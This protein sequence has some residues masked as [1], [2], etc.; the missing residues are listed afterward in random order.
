MTLKPA[1]TT[2]KQT[3]VSI[4]YAFTDL[5]AFRYEDNT[6]DFLKQKKMLDNFFITL[7]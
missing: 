7:V 1:S 6:V 4:K 2:F 3:L 5:N